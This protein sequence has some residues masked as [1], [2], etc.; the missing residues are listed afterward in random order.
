MDQKNIK[1]T[2]ANLTFTV[3]QLVEI[4]SNINDTIRYIKNNTQWDTKEEEVSNAE[5]L[6]AENET[7]E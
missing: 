1:A 6:E 5:S 2:L 7:Q 3:G 4:Q